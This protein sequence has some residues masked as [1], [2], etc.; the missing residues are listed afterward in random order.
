[1]PARA[2]ILVV[3]AAVAAGVV[4]YR[5]REKLLE[6]FDRCGQKIVLSFHNFA[7]GL[8]RERE[9]PMSGRGSLLNAE[10]EKDHGSGDEKVSFY[11]EKAAGADLH[12][13]SSGTASGWNG[14]R[15]DVRHRGS[16]PIIPDSVLFDAPPICSGSSSAS[17]VALKVPGSVVSV[18]CPS[19]GTAA[20]D[21]GKALPTLP[22]PPPPPPKRQSPTEAHSALGEMSSAPL[23]PLV[24]AAVSNETSRTASSNGDQEDRPRNPFENSQPYWS[25]HEW[26]EN[27]TS[28]LGSPSI[29]GSAA[30]ELPLPA[31]DILSEFG[32]SD[33]S[34]ASWTEVGSS[35]DGEDEN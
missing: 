31:D 10:D 17:G 2:L 21:S 24:P 23:A 33:E 28:N 15:G 5:E 26:A 16:P 35:V 1:M 3:T 11:D 27:A 14:T 22:P 12:G 29:A 32:S 4:V 34:V 6:L 7:D 9:A 8:N 20:G 19:S 13:E 30:E 18:S 25:I